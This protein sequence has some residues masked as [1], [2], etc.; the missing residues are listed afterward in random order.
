M[1]LASPW[2]IGILTSI[3]YFLG[4]KAGVYG[5]I[6]VEGITIAWPPN[7]F[8]LVVLLLTPYR[9]WRWILP[10]IILAEVA[11]DYP[12][13]SLA[14]SFAFALVNIFECTLAAWLLRHFSLQ[15]PFTLSNLRNIVLFGVG[16]LGIA[17]GTAAILGAAIYITT[18][19]TTTQ[20]LIFWRIWW[21]G[22]ALGLLI[23]VP[24]LL[25]WLQNYHALTPEPHQEA[26]FEAY[27]SKPLTGKALIFRWVEVTTIMLLTSGLAF[28]IFTHSNLVSNHFPAGPVLMMPLFI[29]AAARFSL[30]GVALLNFIVAAIAIY[31][32]V[33]GLGP[34]SQI[35][36]TAE[37]L[38]LQEYLA[39]LALSSITLAALLNEIKQSNF[40]IRLLDRAISAID[41]GVTITDRQQTVV[42]HNSGFQT[43]SGYSAKEIQGRNMRFL[44]PENLDQSL[45]RNQIRKALANEETARVLL[46]NQRKDGS[47]FWNDLVI[48]PIKDHNQQVSHYVGIQHDVSEQVAT[49][50]ELQAVKKALEETN[51][52][53]EQRVQERTQALEKSNLELERLASTDV[54]TGCANRRMAT[55]RIDAEF[56]RARRYQHTFACLLCDLDFFKQIN[57]LY[58]H[59]TGDLALQNFVQI[60]QA[61]LRSVDLLARFGGE[62]F[63]MVLP[64]TTLE[65]AT[66]IANRICAAVAKNCLQDIDT[67]TPF[68]F[69]VSIGVTSLLAEDKHPKEIISRAD[70]AL[71]QAKEQGRNQAFVM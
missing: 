26:S 65:E 64:E 39:A 44:Q 42:Y 5:A 58:G 63:L 4:A 24:L 53:L 20:F 37:T 14:Q 54:L 27:F 52:Q 17:S 6:L 46:Q 59:A 7:A 47:L 23:I 67:E 10:W 70:K 36:Q 71:Y 68:S 19:E 18:T 11:A 2:A 41:E 22:D 62:E 50:K 66:N 56:A 21:F 49:L 13:F 61:E 29:W 45:E 55:Q 9:H 12:H 30:K 51:R 57:D 31:A 34:F 16:A 1:V 33:M 32:T 8:L 38:V 60:A 15:T 35:D 3:I 43:L 40:R 25:S 69:T 48:T 28:G